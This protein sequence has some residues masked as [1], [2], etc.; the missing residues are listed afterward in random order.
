MR[1]RSTGR[2]HLNLRGCP[3]GCSGMSWF[4]RQ[5]LLCTSLSCGSFPGRAQKP[6]PILKAPDTSK[7]KVSVRKDPLDEARALLL[8]DIRTGWRRTWQS[9]SI[10]TRNTPEVYSQGN[11]NKPSES[12]IQ[13]ILAVPNDELSDSRPHISLVYSYLKQ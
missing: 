2:S 10:L 6:S 12:F 5:A 3:K 13:S 11:V 7:R 8:Q 4:P 9:G 1:G